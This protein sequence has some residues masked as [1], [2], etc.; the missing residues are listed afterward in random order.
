MAHFPV[1]DH[2]DGRRFYNP[3]ALRL[4]SPPADRRIDPG[5]ASILAWQRSLR[6]RWPD[7]LPPPRR[8]VLPDLAPGA[9]SVTFINHSSFLIRIGRRGQPPLAV[10]TDPILS[11]RCSPFRHFGPARVVAPG[12]DFRSLPAIDLVLVSH[13]HYDHLD[14][15]TLRRIARRDDPVC[16]APIGNRR[17]LRGL[18]F[19][20]IRSLD[21]WDRT[22]TGLAG[23]PL[24]TLTPALHGSARTPFDANKALWG[25]FHLRSA[26]ETLFFAGDTA[27]G[28]HWDFIRDRL[29]PPDLALLPIGAYEPVSLMHDVH[30]TPEQA[31]DAALRL[32]ARRAVAMHFGTFQLTDEGYWEPPGRL[33]R[34]LAASGRSPDWFRVPERGETILLP[35]R[36]DGIPGEKAPGS[37]A[38]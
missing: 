12:L 18:G 35:G 7:D 37:R 2:H 14:R 28:R 20:R 11:A 22:G 19:S 23:G 34:A 8:V 21:W 30:M 38:S 17:H 16:I 3:S 26:E 36:T 27:H 1:S 33:S 5:F 32:E 31:L 29:G 4:A 15:P 25:G 24:V 6:P 10:L 13:C 9:F